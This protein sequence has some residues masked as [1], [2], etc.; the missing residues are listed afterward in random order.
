MGILGFG[1]ATK[2]EDLKVKDLKNERLTQEVK[3]DQ[4]LVRIR[5]AQEQHEALLEVASEPGLNDG[6]IDVAAYKMSQIIKV[7]DRAEQELQD[8][9]TRISVI[10]ST[11]DVL[12]QK[13]E[14]QKNGIWKKINEIPEEEMDSQL[15]SLAVERKQRQINLNKI[16]EMF[17]V[18]HQAIKA[19]RSAEFRRSKE[20]ILAKKEQKAG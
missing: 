19:K 15:E 18:D 10:D 9:L 17:D 11:V 1:G 13:Q 16:V 2:L 4:L 8:A 20:T 5:H 6:E 12:N 3:Q 7:R 14:L